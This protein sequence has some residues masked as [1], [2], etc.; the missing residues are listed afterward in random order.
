MAAQLYPSGQLREADTFPA[1]LGAALDARVARVLDEAGVPNF[2]WGDCYLLIIGARFTPGFSGWVV[3]DELI[4]KAKEALDKDGFP[5]CFQ[6][7]Q[8]H[9]YWK[10]L[11][12][13]FP[14]CHYH[15]DLE[16]PEKPQRH[17]NGTSPSH[18]VLL[19]KQSRLFWEFPRPPLGAPAPYDQYY[20]LTSDPRIKNWPDSDSNSNG[21]GRHPEGRYPVKMA[22]PARYAEAMVLSHIRYLRADNVVKFYWERVFHHLINPTYVM[23]LNLKIDDINEPF[24]EFVKR[25]VSEEHCKKVDDSWGL[26]YSYRLWL[27]MKKR[28]Q[29]PPPE[30]VEWKRQQTVLPLEERLQQLKVPYDE[31]DLKCE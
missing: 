13:P 5:G 17:A 16:Y 6:G 20:M 18:G 23:A 24:R 25:W 21:R 1:K 3:P 11:A 10:N 31:S 2:T 26:R 14:D 12:L 19:Y 28:K 4:D 15:T 9:Y 22:V 30:R 8:C 29:L 7:E 27:D